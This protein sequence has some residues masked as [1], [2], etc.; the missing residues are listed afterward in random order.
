MTQ[1]PN[2]N[3]QYNPEN[4]LTA[5]TGTPSA[6]FVYD[7]DGN[8]VLSTING[9]T[10]AYIGSHSEWNVTAQEMTRSYLAGSQ[11]VAFRVIKSG[12]PGGHNTA[13]WR[14]AKPRRWRHRQRPG[15][16]WA[17]R[18]GAAAFRRSS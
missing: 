18:S 5:V 15:T 8:R 2:Q 7:G 12:Q 6:S 11:R 1:R 4:Q 3:L 14:G 9:V 10:T 13:G 17:G 16:A